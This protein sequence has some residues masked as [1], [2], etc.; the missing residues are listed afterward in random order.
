VV[1]WPED[2]EHIG[3]WAVFQLAHATS[4]HFRFV[5]L[6]VLLGISHPAPLLPRY[7]KH[8]P[9]GPTLFVGFGIGDQAMW[10][11]L[12]TMVSLSALA[13]LAACEDKSNNMP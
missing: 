9:Q 10:I 7:R 11:V 13:L 1:E 12:A 6:A 2:I 4:M 5:I 8:S 3:T